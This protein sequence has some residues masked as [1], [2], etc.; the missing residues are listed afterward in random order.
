MTDNHSNLT[1]HQNLQLQPK[2]TT[3]VST[4]ENGFIFIHIDSTEIN[5][6]HMYGINQNLKR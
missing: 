5:Y 4:K 6:I 2:T 3:G 1:T